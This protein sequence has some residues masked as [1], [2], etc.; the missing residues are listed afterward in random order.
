MGQEKALLKIGNVPLIE[1]VLSRLAFQV[2]EVVINANGDTQRFFGLGCAVV[3]DRIITVST[4]LAG[5]H[6]ALHHATTLG[7]AAVVTVPSDTPFLPLDLV[8]RL[9]EAGTVKGAA[10]AATLGQPHYLT[11]IWTVALLPALERRIRD[12]GLRRVKDFAAEAEA[13]IVTWSDLPHDPFFNI[14]T[15]EDLAL[16]ETLV[17]GAAA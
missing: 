17:E 15:P 11:G 8:D 12:S 13:E 14:N 3:P 9:K 7:F 6:A 1:R 5:I 4:P 2:D 16:A 10:F